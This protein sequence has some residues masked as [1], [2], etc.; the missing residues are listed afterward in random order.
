MRTPDKKALQRPPSIR[1]WASAATFSSGPA[2]AR[3]FILEGAGGL[4][5]IAETFTE[6]VD[7]VL[8]NDRRLYKV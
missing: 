1:C 5:P 3:F 7:L 8:R 4:A 6:F 2:V